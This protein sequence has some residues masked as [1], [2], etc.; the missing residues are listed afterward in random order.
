GPAADDDDAWFGWIRHDAGKWH[1][2]KCVAMG[3][4]ERGREPERLFPVARIIGATH[5]ARP[6]TLAA[7]AHVARPDLRVDVALLCGVL[8]LPQAVLDREERP[9]ARAPFHARAALLCYAAYLVSYTL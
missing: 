3:V 7:H 9:R 2:G 8:L 5:A 1:G 6:V 4:Y